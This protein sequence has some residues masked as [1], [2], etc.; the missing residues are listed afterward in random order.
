MYTKEKLQELI[1]KYKQYKKDKKSENL[2][3][4]E[5]R[6]WINQFLAIFEWDVLN[7][8]QIKQEKIVNEYQKS[9]LTEIDSIHTKP[10]YSLVN[11]NA[12]KE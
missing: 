7:T 6:S 8:K 11:G 2:S 3:E 4:E 12:V 5:T 10:D 9:K 1:L